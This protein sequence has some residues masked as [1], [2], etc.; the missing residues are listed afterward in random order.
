M[1]RMDGV[2][3]LYWDA[4]IGQVWMEIPQIYQ[5]MIHLMG[6]RAGLGSNDLG[7]NRGGGG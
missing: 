4:D 5:E 6:F 2:L 1:Q 7:L 3:P